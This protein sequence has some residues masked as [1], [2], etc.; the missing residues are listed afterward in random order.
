MIE[1]YILEARD[2][3][4][5]FLAYFVVNESDRLKAEEIVKATSL[6]ESVRF[7]KDLSSEEISSWQTALSQFP[8]ASSFDLVK[9]K[10]MDLATWV[11]AS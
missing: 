2:V 11:H 4:E 8:I 6:A 1:G 10:C 3:N 9:G 5:K 7:V